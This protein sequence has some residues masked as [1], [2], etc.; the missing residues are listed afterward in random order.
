MAKS[1]KSQ[2]WIPQSYLAA[3]TDP[4]VL[5]DH[6]PFVHLYARDGSRERRKAPTN[7]FKETD[8]YT[9]KM[10]DGT[11]NLRLERGLK[12]LEQSFCTVRRDFLD[13]RRSL[14]PSRHEKLVTFVAAMHVRTPVMRD[15]HGEFWRDLR[16][17]C[18]EMMT[19]I[20]THTLD[21]KRRIASQTIPSSDESR[22]LSYEQVVKLA[23]NPMQSLLEPFIR[24]EAPKLVLMHETIL[25]TDND[26]GFITSDAPV[27][28]F[29]PDWYKRPPRDQSP[30]FSCSKLEITMPIS[31]HQLLLLTHGDTGLTYLDVPKLVVSEINRRTRFECDKEF[32]VRRSYQ[33]P[34]WFEVGE[35]PDNAWN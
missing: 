17:L 12:G 9:I 13:H 33:E 10:P 23:E 19:S 24:A 2:H 27:V 6:I 20:K 29:D 3:W 25:C 35:I 21:E 30:A 26:P 11:R 16:S 22:G 14:P 5:E 32:V 1:H 28:W 8:L 31:P 7:I 18:E 4:D 15:H 34:Y